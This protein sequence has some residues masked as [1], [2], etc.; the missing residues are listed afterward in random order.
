MAE[1]RDLY[2]TADVVFPRGKW[3][4]YEMHVTKTGEVVKVV[5][6]PYSKE[7][8]G[9]YDVQQKQPGEEG[10]EQLLRIVFAALEKYNWKAIQ[11]LE[12][13]H[14]ELYANLKANS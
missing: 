3:T 1:V 11:N 5:I 7:K 13:D 9:Y 6:S 2:S 10:F 8:G 12:N 14:P 4:G